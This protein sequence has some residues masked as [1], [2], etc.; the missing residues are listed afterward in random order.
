ML[1]KSN[2]SSFE[3]NTIFSPIRVFKKSSFPDSSLEKYCFL[4]FW[5]SATHPEIKLY[6]IK[7]EESLNNC[8]PISSAQFSTLKVISPKFN[9]LKE[10][11]IFNSGSTPSLTPKIMISPFRILTC[12]LGYKYFFLYEPLSIG[13]ISDLG[14][15]FINTPLI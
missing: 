8:V 5:F 15:C 3:I 6:S 2:P 13:T 4:V 7:D 14:N 9:S 1:V 11:F 10:S 12:I